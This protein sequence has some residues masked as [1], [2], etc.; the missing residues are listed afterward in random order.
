MP[1]QRR[2]SVGNIGFFSHSQGQCRY[3]T[4]R[5]RSGSFAQQIR[6]QLAVLARDGDYPPHCRPKPV[7]GL[8][9]TSAKRRR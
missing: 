1:S 6:T 4:R 9:A 2:K 5:V 3:P 8:A 7:H